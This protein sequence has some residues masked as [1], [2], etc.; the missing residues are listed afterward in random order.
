[1]LKVGVTGG[2]GSGKTTVCKI[3]ETLGIPVYAADE[4]AKALMQTD[5]T[6]IRSIKEIFGD[7]AYQSG[8]LNRAFIAAQ[9]FESK[10]LLAQLNSIVHPAVAQ[11]VLRW[12]QQQEGKPYMIEEAALLFESGSYKHFDKIITVVA[13]LSDRIARLKKRDMATDEQITARMNNQM[14]DEEKIKL[15]DFIIYNDMQHR[16]IEQ[17]LSIHHALLNY[18]SEK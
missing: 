4:R 5:Q 6:L 10:P 18:A 7:A 11:D 2:I 13:P 8:R 12:M 9:V 14:S 3:F 17:T 16:L 1:M 15:S